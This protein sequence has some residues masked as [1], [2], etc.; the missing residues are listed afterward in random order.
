M[1][2]LRTFGNLSMAGYDCLYRAGW[3]GESLRGAEMPLSQ[4]YVSH[5]FDD[6]E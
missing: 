2:T 3:T 6:L 1:L 4:I 5:H